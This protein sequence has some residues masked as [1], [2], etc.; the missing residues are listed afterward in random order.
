MNPKNGKEKV[1][2]IPLESS[3][4]NSSQEN[5]SQENDSQENSSQN[6]E[7]ELEVTLISNECEKVVKQKRRRGKRIETP[8]K[9]RVALASIIAN[10]NVSIHQAGDVLQTIK[11][12][13]QPS[14]KPQSKETVTRCL[15]ETYL[16][17]SIENA[18]E[19]SILQNLFIILDCASDRCQRN[20]IGIKFGGFKDSK[21]ITFV[22]CILE[23]TNHTAIEQVNCLIETLKFYCSFQKEYGWDV[24][25]LYDFELIIYDNTSSNRGKVNGVFAVL[26][27][28]RKEVWLEES[29]NF[30]VM[31]PFKELKE[32]GCDD[33]TINLSSTEYEKRLVI[34][35]ENWSF[36]YLLTKGKKH[37]ATFVALHLY[38]RLTGHFRRQFRGFLLNKKIK[39]FKFIRVVETRF[40][41]IEICSLEI[42]RYFAYIILFL[43]ECYP[44]LTDI[45]K[46]IFAALCNI[47]VLAVL[48]IRAFKAFHFD[49]PFMKS[50]NLISS[51]AEYINLIQEC[52]QQIGMV[53]KDPMYVLNNQ[54]IPRIGAEYDEKVNAIVQKRYS[55]YL[56]NQKGKS[57]SASTTLIENELIEKDVDEIS[58]LVIL[59]ENDDVDDEDF[60][61]IEVELQTNHVVNLTHQGS[62]SQKDLISN[63]L[64]SLKAPEKKKQTA[65]EA[66]QRIQ[67]YV[68]TAM[69]SLLFQLM[70]HNTKYFKDGDDSTTFGSVL[71][72]TSREVER[73]FGQTKALLSKNVN[74]RA[75][76]MQSII[77][78]RGIETN[79]LIELVQKF[80]KDDVLYST[81]RKVIDAYHTKFDYDHLFFLAWKDECKK[82]EN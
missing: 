14:Q 63:F 72:A 68:V 57:G 36:N 37:A 59:N 18:H 30:K 60:A 5:Y 35:T 31:N 55:E 7:N 21:K 22:A 49:L 9:E 19:L 26:N 80:S 54:N 33:H 43:E 20:L 3:Q 78:I 61:D 50:C 75:L 56:E 12:L 47:D 17:V 8:L 28:K 81:G 29:Q 66:D 64:S 27:K 69:E 6:E 23:I 13:S 79:R 25:K 52:E 46:K 76:I 38:Q 65:P 16:A 34:L 51:E 2:D 11:G 71:V 45:D 32:K 4:E 77:T 58:D 48:K 62:N 40:S 10:N 82:N 39:P 70:K 1:M 41:S 53:I 73:I 42:Y 24:T 15:Q 44:I 67:I 74:F